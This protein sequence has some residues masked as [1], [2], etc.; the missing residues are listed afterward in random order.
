MSTWLHEALANPCLGGTSLG[1]FLPLRVYVL[2]H[3][4]IPLT[5]LFHSQYFIVTYATS[6]QMHY[7]T[8]VKPKKN[9]VETLQLLTSNGLVVSRLL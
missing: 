5:I 3:S 8:C 7:L 4:K 1:T 9:K 6:N 2:R